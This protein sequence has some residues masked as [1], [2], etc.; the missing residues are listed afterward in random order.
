MV[1]DP[2][3]KAALLQGLHHECP[4]LTDRFRCEAHLEGVV[5]LR[6]A[7]AGRVEAC[8]LVEQR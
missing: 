3:Q 6:L 7:Q 5:H 8:L 2:G 4:C 1:F